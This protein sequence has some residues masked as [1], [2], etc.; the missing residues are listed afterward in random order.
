MRFRIGVGCF[1]VGTPCVFRRATESR[2]VR[3]YESTQQYV[4]SDTVFIFSL[5]SFKSRF[6]IKLAVKY[7]LVTTTHQA[8]IELRTIN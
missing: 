1:S 8:A 6:F 3:I 5:F 2:K 7:V 4:S